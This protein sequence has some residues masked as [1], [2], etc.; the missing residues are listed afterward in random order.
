[1]LMARIAPALAT[2]AE[3]EGVVRAIVDAF[4]RGTED[5]PELW[6][7]VVHHPAERAPGA[8]IVA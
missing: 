5:E 3:P 1:M 8:E 2:E 7:F 4:L 6:R